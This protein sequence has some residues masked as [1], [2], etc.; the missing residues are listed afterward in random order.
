[1]N[2]CALC[3]EKTETFYNI[4]YKKVHIC[5]NCALTITKQE[6]ASWEPWD[7]Q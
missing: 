5:E 6:V 7:K 1:M 2:I 3:K 4:K